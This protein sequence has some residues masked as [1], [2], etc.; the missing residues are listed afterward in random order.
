MHETC[1]VTIHDSS[2]ILDMDNGTLYKQMCSLSSWP[3]S[4]YSC[5]RLSKIDC[6][7][8]QRVKHVCLSLGKAF[9]LNT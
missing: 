5:E 7:V 4:N 8:R 1:P 3:N 2:M 6:C 9:T